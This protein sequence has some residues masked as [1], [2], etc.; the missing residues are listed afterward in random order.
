MCADSSQEF[1]PRACRTPSWS[2]DLRTDTPS[3]TGST[4]RWHRIRAEAAPL[5]E[6][7]CRATSPNH[8]F[9][10]TC[11]PRPRARPLAVSRLLADSGIRRPH[12]KCSWSLLLRPEAP[13]PRTAFRRKRF[14]CSCRFI[15]SYA[16]RNCFVVD[17]AWRIAPVL[18][19]VFTD[20]H[21]IERDTKATE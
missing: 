18:I 16:R 8:G 21:Q 6:R 1:A 19:L 5:P 13:R 17:V 4:H 3:Q 10:E 12:R 9:C 14:A 7:G 15:E 2:R 11:S 20:D